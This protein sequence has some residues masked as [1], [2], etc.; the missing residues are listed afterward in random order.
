MELMRGGLA[1]RF[2]CQYT[3][4]LRRLAVLNRVSFPSKT[5]RGGLLVTHALLEANAAQPRRPS[6]ITLL[7][8]TPSN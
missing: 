7:H 6:T 2:D 1:G 4:L 8:A 5:D 3:Y